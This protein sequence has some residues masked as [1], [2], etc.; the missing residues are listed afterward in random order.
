MSLD[1]PTIWFLVICLE[2]G[3]YVILD[4]ADLGIGVLTLVPQKEDQRSLLM[5]T[6]GPIWDANETWLVIA[7]G[8]LF[9]AFPMA[10]GLILNALY[11]PVFVIIF[12]LIIRAVAYE[13]RTISTHKVL[14]EYAFGAGSLLAVFGQGFAVGG[15]LSGITVVNG[16]F[17]GGSFDWLSPITL[18]LTVGITMSY[19]VV[20]YLYLIKK[21]DFALEGERFRHVVMAAGL[22]LV[23]FIGA[24]VLLPSQ[25]YIFFE[26]WTSEPA[27]TILFVI[28]A[29]IAS[30]SVILTYGILREKFHHELHTVCMII[31]ALG[32]V[33]LLI[34][35][36]PYLIP[37][38]ITIYDAA[39]SPATLRFML[40]GIGPLL[41]IVLAYNF[42]LY[43]IFRLDTGQDRSDEY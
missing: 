14:W 9:G 43:R 25:H 6:V 3:L 24:A 27:R 5:H 41:P 1:L 39:A 20:G 31:F 37:P 18:L 34:G 28:T 22:T 36:Y 21:T 4:G 10:Y 17:A 32:F 35:V 26:R 30:S 16:K 2:A 8:T 7:G 12:G 38:S 33:G 13:F 11:I 23:G 40:W 29:L 42:Y 19:V 15:L